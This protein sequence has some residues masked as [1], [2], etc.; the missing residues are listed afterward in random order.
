MAYA[1]NYEVYKSMDAL[2]AATA[3]DPT[4]FWAQ[5]K[6]GELQYRLRAL[7]RAEEE[8]LKAV[9]LAQ[10]SVQLSLARKQL[11]KV[12]ELNRASIRNVTW[13]KPLTKP[14]LVFAGMMLVLF[15]VMVWK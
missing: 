14:A 6:Y 15:L 9:E 7:L 12:R 13:D 8:T 1:V 4:H 10:N 2:E 3:I 11:Q 5:L